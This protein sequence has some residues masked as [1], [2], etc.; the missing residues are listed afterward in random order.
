MPAISVHRFL[1]L[2]SLL[3]IYLVVL[4]GNVRYTNSDPQLTLLTSQAILEQGSLELDTYKYAL[5]KNQFADGDWKTYSRE[6][7][8]Y[9]FYPLGT[10]V[11]SL[12]FVAAARKLG[13]DM[14]IRADDIQLQIF[15]SA[16]LCVLIA[17][18]LYRLALRFTGE[19]NALTAM[20]LLFFGSSWMS[21]LGTALWSFGFETVFILL[22]LTDWIDAEKN[23]KEIKPVKTGLWLFLAWFCR[24]AALSFIL[25]VL[26]WMLYRKKFRQLMWMIPAFLVPF[27]ALVIFSWA[28][29]HEFVPP[30]YNI[31]RWSGGDAE[32]GMLYRFFATLFSPARGLFVFTPLLLVAFAGILFSELRK[33]VIFLFTWI[34]ILLHLLMLARHTGWWGGWCY[35]P[36]LSTDILPAFA[37]LIFMLMPVLEKQSAGLRMKIGLAGIAGMALF[38]IYVHTVQGIYNRETYNWNDL[39]NIDEQTDFYAWNWRYPQFLA[40]GSMNDLKKTEYLWMKDFAFLSREVPAGSALLAGE[41][42]A[43]LRYIFKAIR[44]QKHLYGNVDLYNNL[45]ELKPAVGKPFYILNEQTDFVSDPRYYRLVPEEDTTSLGRFLAKH[46]NEV[47]LLAV[48]DEAST[49]L[50]ETT[51]KYLRGKGAHTDSLKYRQGYVL[52][53]DHG[54]V[55]G[56]IF[57]LGEGAEIKISRPGKKTIELLSLG[58]D[59]GNRSVIRVG[60]EDYSPNRRGF[61]AVVLSD[62]GEPVDVAHFDTHKADRRVRHVTKVERIK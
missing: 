53:L 40:S 32:H 10:P 34:W 55:A 3:G 49:F 12:P 57:D 42:D 52:V 28:N 17:L 62:K 36:R 50:S 61:N 54:K 2:L 51:R 47:V 43:R 45:F 1:L 23:G 30:Y 35:G 59:K 33:N 39:P 16:L 20:L 37:V 13:M 29:I 6:G 7:S 44:K 41:P 26:G 21:T 19:W 48:K 38:G 15:I 4:T 24:P 22:V 9:Y 5:P 56:E 14:T 11:L 25:V 60:E 8:V 27:F 58:M 31:F 46:E 18:L